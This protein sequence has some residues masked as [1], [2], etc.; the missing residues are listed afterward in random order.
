MAESPKVVDGPASDR[1]GLVWMRWVGVSL[2]L[3]DGPAGFDSA[4]R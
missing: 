1:D 2:G 3:R 4:V